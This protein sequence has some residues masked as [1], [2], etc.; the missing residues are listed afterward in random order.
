MWW[1]GRRS[2]CRQSRRSPWPEEEVAGGRRRCPP[3]L[4]TGKGH[5]RWKVGVGGGGGEERRRGE[6]RGKGRGGE[7]KGGGE[8]NDKCSG[9]GGRG[10]DKRELGRRWRWPVQ[11]FLN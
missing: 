7:E 1:K 8:E 6:G 5:R 4:A 3:E 2:P 11:I 10:G 9:G